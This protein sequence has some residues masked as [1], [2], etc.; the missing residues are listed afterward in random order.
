[1]SNTT[2][3]VAL[4]FGLIIG[5]TNPRLAMAWDEKTT[6]I[7]SNS[8]IGIKTHTIHH[9]NAPTAQNI[10]FLRVIGLAPGCEVGTYFDKD[11]NK[12]TQATALAVFVSSGKARI[13]YDVDQSLLGVPLIFARL[14]Q[15]K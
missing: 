3:K 4:I 9:T 2:L 6:T 15:L 13:T 1:M 8:L 7:D 5:F 14:L 10:S 11:L 12:S